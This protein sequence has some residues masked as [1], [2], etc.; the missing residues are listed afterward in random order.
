MAHQFRTRR[1]VEF[2][3]TDMAGILHFSNY[4]RYM[5]AAEHAF[6]RSLG[7]RVHTEGPD[8]AIGFARR[9]AECSYHE[10]LRYEDEVELHVLVREKRRRALVYEV[11]FRRVEAD[12]SAVTEVA[13]GRM[14][15]VCI[16]LRGQGV[17][18][19]V[20]IPAAIDA[21]LDVA[22]GS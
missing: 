10:P 5:E 18:E 11:V 1:R 6:F 19:A 16:A 15:T 8:G 14:V 4:F 12:G 21:L 13:R 22:P 17:L 3:E 7:H 2:A 20:P 9:H